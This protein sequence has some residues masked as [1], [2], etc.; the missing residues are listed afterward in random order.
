MKLGTYAVVKFLSAIPLMFILL[1]AIFFVMRVLPGDP[2]LM[3]VGEKAPQ[4]EIDRIRHELGLDRPI[5]L[6]FFSYL[7]DMVSG[8]FGRSLMT[9]RPIIH[10][11]LEAYPVSIELAIY[12][13]FLGVILGLPIGII[14][15]LKSDTYI[16][17]FLRFIVFATYSMPSFWLGMIF[18]IFF[19]LQLNLLPIS[20]R[21]SVTTEIPKIIGIYTI[22]SLLNMNFKSFIDSIKYLVLP[23]STLAIAIIPR[24]SRIA[25]GNMLDQMREDYITTA[26]AKGIPESQVVYKHA[27]KNSLLPII[28]VIG[29]SFA[30]LLGGTIL[31]ETVFSLPGLGRLLVTGLC[32]RDFP[33]VQAIVFIYALVVAIVNIMI[34][35]INAVIDPRVR[36]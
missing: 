26:R 16:D 30:G 20:G 23:C 28:T 5:H 32:S 17:Q 3:M 9:K 36:F 7:R 2:V 4:T 27:L 8:D 6:Q 12:S 1:T 35:I 25:R 15:A 13:I 21:L 22:D 34:D 19:G 31:I 14:G 33:L 24:I 11:I 10:M 29:L 18:Q